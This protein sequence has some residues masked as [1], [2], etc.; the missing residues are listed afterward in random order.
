MAPLKYLYKSKSLTEMKGASA[1]IVMI[2]VLPTMVVY[3]SRHI[4]YLGNL[5]VILIYSRMQKF[6]HP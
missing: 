6:G 3:M 5:L 1:T 4:V 2:V